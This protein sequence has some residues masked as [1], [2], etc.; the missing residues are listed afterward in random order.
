MSSRRKRFE[1]DFGPRV[2]VQSRAGEQ[3]R[4]KSKPRWAKSSR[5]INREQ[6]RRC[7]QKAVKMVAPAPTSLDRAKEV[8]LQHPDAGRMAGTLAAPHP[9]I[10]EHYCHRSEETRRHAATWKNDRIIVRKTAARAGCCEGTSTKCVRKKQ[11]PVSPW[12]WSQ[13]KPLSETRATLTCRPAGDQ[14]ELWNAF[15]LRQTSR[16]SGARLKPFAQGY[17]L[18]AHHRR[19]F[20]RKMRRSSA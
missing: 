19:P 8:A 17:L 1:R 20:G 6:K 5:Q 12:L 4:S 13:P 11:W 18:R 9:A 3:G 16:A 15:W 2:A 10:D 14:R 7:G